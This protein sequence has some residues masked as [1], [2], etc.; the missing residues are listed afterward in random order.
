MLV[1]LVTEKGQRKYLTK[2]ERIN[3]IQA[4]KKVPP[5]DRTFCLML[6]HTGCLISEALNIRYQDINLPEREVII[7]TLRKRKKKTDFRTIP[8]S[9]YYMDELVYIHKL[10]HQN[11]TS[12]DAKLWSWSRGG[13]FRK[14]KDV[15][16]KAEIKGYHA[17]PL[18]IRH[19]FG[20]YCAENDIP[21][22]F[23]RK[24]MGHSSLEITQMYLFNKVQDERAMAK[25][26]WT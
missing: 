11:T 16:E 17:T 5:I 4:T 14:V 21:L 3:F 6:V 13:G 26:M 23:I 8:L 18:G 9:D 25:K 12:S 19:S 1:Q 7:H 22:T 2:D 20:L 10:N 24:W 15:M